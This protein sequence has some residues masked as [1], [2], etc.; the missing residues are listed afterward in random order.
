MAFLRVKRGFK[1]DK[2][3]KKARLE[4][5]KTRLDLYIKAEAA[6]LEGAQSYTI[7]SRHLTRAD[8]AEI[9]KMISS[10][11]DGIDELEAEVSGR[12]RRKCIRVIPRDV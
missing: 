7:G 1:M 6:I 3:A 4:L 5:Y 12:S 11:E 10:L 2:T 9:R 8:L